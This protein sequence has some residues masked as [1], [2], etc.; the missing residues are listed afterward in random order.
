[1]GFVWSV[2]STLQLLCGGTVCLSP[3]VKFCWSNLLED[4]IHTGFA[5]LRAES[6]S[7][8]LCNK[9]HCQLFIFDSLDINEK[10]QLI[11]CQSH[12]FKISRHKLLS[13]VSFF[14]IFK[15]FQPFLFSHQKK[16]VL[17]IY[18]KWM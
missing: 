16:Y 17:H 3:P 6:P 13:N 15:F 10:P 18:H 1:M 2:G 4:S 9:I 11:Y 5:V 7:L 8:F 12:F 14:E